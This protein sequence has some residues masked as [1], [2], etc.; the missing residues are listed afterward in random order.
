MQRIAVVGFQPDAD[1]YKGLC[2]LLTKY[3]VAHV[4]LPMNESS[5]FIKSALKAIAD[6]GAKLDLYISV[7]AEIEGPMQPEDITICS[8][9]VKE[10]MRLLNSDDVLALVWDDSMEAHAVLHS[11]EDLGLE[12]WDISDG[13]DPL[14]IDY[15]EDDT[16]E[17]LYDAMQ[18]SLEVFTENLAAYV[19]ASVLEILSETILQRMK[20]D[21]GTKD[22]MPFDDDE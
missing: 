6:K 9:P 8:N 13:L 12:A 17:V 10:V 5:L 19:T 21:E 18:K 14:E 7:S 20:E 11:M 3:P 22:I 16:S 4:L 2:E 1:V 15:E